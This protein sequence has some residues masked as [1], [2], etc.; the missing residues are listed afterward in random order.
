MSMGRRRRAPGGDG[1]RLVL[2]WV[3]AALL[4]LACLLAALQQKE[5]MALEERLPRGLALY[6]WVA[7][8][9]WATRRDWE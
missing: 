1:V 3:G 2:K 9:L 6:L 5:A 7:F 4:V 8:V